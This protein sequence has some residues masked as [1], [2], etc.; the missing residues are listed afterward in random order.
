MSLVV[1][2][3][4]CPFNAPFPPSLRS[5][6]EIQI[7]LFAGSS[8]G[9]SF[10]RSCPSE[11]ASLFGANLIFPPDRESSPSTIARCVFCSKRIASRRSSLFSAIPLPLARARDFAGVFAPMYLPMMSHAW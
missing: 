6:L 11:K 10:R 4:G 5:L 8:S 7:F 2:A 9:S 1:S 3:S